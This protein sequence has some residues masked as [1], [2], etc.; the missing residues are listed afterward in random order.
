[1]SRSEAWVLPWGLPPA[2]QQ[3]LPA[4]AR[5]LRGTGA[6]QPLPPLKSRMPAWSPRLQSHSRPPARFPV[7]RRSAGQSLC[8]L[9]AQTP[10]PS[11]SEPLPAPGSVHTQLEQAVLTTSRSPIAPIASYARRTMGAR[12]S[13]ADVG[14][15]LKIRIVSRQATLGNC[16]RPRTAP[17]VGGPCEAV[18]RP[19]VD[20]WLKPGS[21]VYSTVDTLLRLF[22]L[23]VRASPS[24]GVERT[25]LATRLGPAR[26]MRERPSNGRYRWVGPLTGA[27]DAIDG[28]QARRLGMLTARVRRQ[29][30]RWSEQHRR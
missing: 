8:S 14:F 23:V 11:P 21:M 12:A 2:L 28:H 29:G 1:M 9:I 5:P 3:M 13:H 24:G 7:R 25:S 16:L 6:L 10:R 30:M 20:A 26:Q 19:R 17:V 27:R 18:D 22:N 4:R 15:G